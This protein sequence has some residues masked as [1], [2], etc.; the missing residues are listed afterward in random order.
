MNPQHP[1]ISQYEQH[2]QEKAKV[3]AKREVKERFTPE[4]WHVVSIL[5][6]LSLISAIFRAQLMALSF[7]LVLYLGFDTYLANKIKSMP[8]ARGTLD[9]DEEVVHDLGGDL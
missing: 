5:I 4:R 9:K 7:F 3:E 1:I 8:S 6:A 2:L